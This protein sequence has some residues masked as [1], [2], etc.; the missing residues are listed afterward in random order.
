VGESS[1]LLKAKAKLDRVS[2]NLLMLN[3]HFLMK[4]ICALTISYSF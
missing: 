3:C 4:Q 1:I 2:V